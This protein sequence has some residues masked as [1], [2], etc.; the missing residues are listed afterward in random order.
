[1]VLGA[2]HRQDTVPSS[3]GQVVQIHDL[4]AFCLKDG[5]QERTPP[6]PHLILPLGRTALGLPKLG[7]LTASTTDFPHFVRWSHLRQIGPRPS[8]RSRTSWSVY[9]LGRRSR[10]L[11]DG[12]RLS[13]LP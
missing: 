12:T 1:M 8:P 6:F 2:S 10:W 5:P 13:T 4:P 11:E 7:F 9:A 3:C